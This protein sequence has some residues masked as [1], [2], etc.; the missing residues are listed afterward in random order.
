MAAAARSRPERTV[1]VVDD[2]ELVCRLT[3]RVLVEAGFRV[4]EAHSA[5][6]ALARL[7]ALNGAVQLVVSD[8]GMPKMSGEQ[9]ASAIAERWPAVPVLLVSGQGG[10]QS[11]Y[12]GTFLPK[13]FTPDALLTVVRQIIPP[14]E[15]TPLMA[16][17]LE[18]RVAP[19]TL[20]FRPGNHKPGNGP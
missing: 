7:T 12:R 6:D 4:H 16:E 9:L 18:E 8:I 2:E 15:E 13:P 19:S 20:D 10:P 3:A 14:A 17:E 5:L 1:L 11:D